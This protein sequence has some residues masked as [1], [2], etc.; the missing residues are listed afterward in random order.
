[1]AS[2][3]VNSL[4]KMARSEVNSLGKMAIIIVYCNKRKEFRMFDRKITNQ[5]EIWLDLNKYKK[6]ALLIKGLRQVGKTYIAQKF[7]E[8]HFENIVYIDFKN[9]PS[10]KAIFDS[11]FDIN[12]IILDISAKHPNAK[13]VP[14][15]TVLIFD[16]IQECLNARACIKAFMLD[17]R[18][19]II[20]TG[21]LLG[22]RGY[23]KKKSVGIPA[24]YEYILNMYAMDFEEFLWAKKI[25]KSVISYL[26]DCYLN[27]VKISDTTHKTMLKY[28]TEYICVGGLPSIVKSYL[29]TSDMGI[30]YSEQKSIIDEYRDDFGKHL[31]VNEMEM[32]DFS[33]LAKINQVFD[34]IPSQLAKE[35]KKFQYSTLKKN[36]RARSYYSAI[37]WLKDYGI[38][39][40]CYN[41]KVPQ[42]PL[43]GNKI[44]NIFKL[45]LQDTGIFIAMLG[46][47]AASNVLSGNLG[48]YK[49]AIYENIIADALTKSEKPLYY[50][51]K[52][53]GLEID[54]VSNIA[55]EIY[56][57]ECKATTG[58]A[59]SL[60]TIH[61]KPNI[62]GKTA[63]IKLGEYNIGESNGVKTVPYYLSF[64][65]F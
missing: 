53:S 25:D 21:S 13:F 5:M 36:G 37:Q 14:N 3:E 39:N 50:F 4:G 7:A 29:K 61:N 19:D 18:F 35:N 10:F 62:Y 24:G 44:E 52:E 59:K 54:F 47:E 20:C 26:K 33:L 9:N 12:R 32:T 30:V 46:I 42:F 60:K 49:G 8:S 34:S 38:V 15:K 1:M 48:Y 2:S 28:F 58:D 22:I 57:I 43:E 56:L 55:E 11:D 41:L 40:I 16:E 31:D 63:A 23:N 6:R 51:H 27:I 17:G 45:Y 64:C 65:I